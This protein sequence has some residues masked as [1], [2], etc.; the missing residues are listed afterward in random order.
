MR[1]D[2]FAFDLPREL[3]ADLIRASRA[4]PPGCC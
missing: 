3:I 2:D 1:L 4:T